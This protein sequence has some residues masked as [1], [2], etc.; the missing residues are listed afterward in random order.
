MSH[1]SVCIL[2]FP[3]SSISQGNRNPSIS[4]TRKC[5]EDST[6]NL[7][8][9]VKSCE[10][11]V[12]DPSIS[13]ASYAHGSSYNKA[14]LRYLISRWV[15]ECHQTFSIIND[16]PLQLILK[17]LYAKVETPS[18]TTVSHDIKEI[19]TI[20]KVHVGS[21]LQVCLSIHSSHYKHNFLNCRHTQVVYTLASMDGPHPTSSHSLGWLFILLR[22]ARFNH[23]SWT[24][25][26]MSP[27]FF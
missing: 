20:S 2:F 5:E 18:Q 25:S 3:C 15:F 22:K 4:L 23:S 16:P 17:M 26:C 12:A 8:C 24:S 27:V 19:H 10:G 21:Y 14:K 9:H 6:T 13:I 1:V 7:V 11:Q